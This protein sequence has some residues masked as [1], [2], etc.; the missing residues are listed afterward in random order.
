MAAGLVA[1][2]TPVM[3]AA[4]RGPDLVLAYLADEPTNFT[5]EHV[6]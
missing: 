5:R 3:A 1:Q 4:C 6:Q 2:L